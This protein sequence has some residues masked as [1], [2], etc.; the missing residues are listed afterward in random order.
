MA[1]ASLRYSLAA[2]RLRCA[3]ASLRRGCGR[4]VPILLEHGANPNLINGEG[5]TVL[6][7]LAERAVREQQQRTAVQ[8]QQ[9]AAG[10][11]CDGGAGSS[12]S[13]ADEGGTAAGGAPPSPPELPV[14]R[15]LELLSEHSLQ[16]DAQE[17]QTGNTALHHAAFGG[18]IELAV[19]LVSLG[20]SVGLPNKVPCCG[21]FGWE[22]REA[23]APLPA[24]AA[25]PP[26]SALA[27]RPRPIYA[28]SIPD[29]YPIYT[30]PTLDL[31]PT[32][33]VQLAA[34]PPAVRSTAQD[35]FTP[36][37]SSYRSASDPTRSIR[38]LLLS[39]IHK[40]SSWTP[41]RMARARRREPA[42]PTLL[43]RALPRRC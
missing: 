11:G 34:A 35:G 3:T 41:D 37:D 21:A 17:A 25:M 5:Q 18:C 42:R 43:A 29:L 2:L 4:Y 38:S 10:N 22:P 32:Y 20:A 15:L 23:A 14:A 9:H 19:Q 31:R 33:A 8:G 12:C 1:L 26:A 6:H 16:L 30:R 7:L 28:R 27:H 24:H 36:L 40:P 13:S 39:K